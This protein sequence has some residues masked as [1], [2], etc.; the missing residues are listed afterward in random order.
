MVAHPSHSIVDGGG[1]PRFGT[2]AFGGSGEG[3]E[4]DGKRDECL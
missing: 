3:E 2:K 1:G 4:V